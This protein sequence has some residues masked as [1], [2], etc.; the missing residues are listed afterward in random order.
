MVL[1]PPRLTRREFFSKEKNKKITINLINE[2]KINNY[3]I[4][5]KDGKFSQ[6]N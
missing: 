4:N 5:N 2:L 6:K 3:E 1:D